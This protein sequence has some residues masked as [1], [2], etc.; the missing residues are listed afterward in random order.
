MV[1][2][3]NGE[4]REICR[5]SSPFIQDCL[6]S[7][8]STDLMGH[9]VPI[10]PLDPLDELTDV[11]ETDYPGG[12]D[13]P[14]LLQRYKDFLIRLKAKGLNPW[15]DQPRRKDLHLTEAVGHFHLFAWL[16]EAVGGECVVSPEFP[17]GNGKV[18]L[19]LRWGDKQG[20]IEVKSFERLSVLKKDQLR[21]ADYARSMGL[22]AV[23]MAVFVP[24]EDETVLAKLSG[25]V[26][27]EGVQVEVVAIGWM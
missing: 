7:A 2:Q 17:T 3:P 9:K 10:L 14:A 25:H 18:D 22:T 13:L 4:L 15:Q 27:I 21:A 1:E 12:L 16:K 26:V 20:L 5:F 24:V 23:T 11:F 6:Y 19:H 8:L